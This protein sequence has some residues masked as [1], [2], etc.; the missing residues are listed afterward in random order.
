MRCKRALFTLFLGCMALSVLTGCRNPFSRNG[1]HGSGGDT[2]SIEFGELGALPAE[3]R[4][5]DLFGADRRVAS[6]FSPVY[7]GYD[8]A[9]VTG[10]ES[11]KLLHVADYMQRSPDASLVV[12]GHCDERGSREYNMTLGERRA[13]A[14]RAYLVG[15]GVDP[16]RVQTRSF[17]EERPA[18]TGTGEAVWG[19]NR[20]AEFVI[21]K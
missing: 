6:E 4:D 16:Q 19:R 10:A 18:A 12:E 21:Y 20:R 1:G 14:A 3:G 7:F 11:E 8:S 17:G 13:L 15:L 2:D 5:S 9:Q